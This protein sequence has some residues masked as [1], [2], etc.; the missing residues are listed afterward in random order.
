MYFL[1]LFIANELF[2]RF[3]VVVLLLFSVFIQF[4]GRA[5]KLY[6]RI[7]SQFYCIMVRGSVYDIDS[8]Q[9][10]SIYDVNSLELTYF[11]IFLLKSLFKSLSF[12]SPWC[13]SLKIKLKLSYCYCGIN[14]S[15]WFFNFCSI[16]R[17]V[18]CKL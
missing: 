8:L 2:R 7:Y 17:E 6:F 14:F 1:L 15:L 16:Y 9:W 5:G 11:W 3:F 12:L 4:F 18:C 10:L 13:N